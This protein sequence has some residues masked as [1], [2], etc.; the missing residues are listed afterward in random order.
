MQN[1]YAFNPKTRLSRIIRQLGTLALVAAPAT[2]G[3]WSRVSHGHLAAAAA[4]RASAFQAYASA[5]GLVERVVQGVQDADNESEKVFTANLEKAYPGIRMIRGDDPTKVQHT[6]PI[7]AYF[8]PDDTRL[9][10]ALECL[11][12]AHG[13]RRQAITEENH[14]AAIRIFSDG[15]HLVQDYFAHLNAPGRGNTGFSHGVGNLIDTNG[16]GK[17]ETPA[18]R[19]VDNVYWDCH[20]DLGN[21]RVPEHL[22][23]INYFH[24]PF[25]HKC[26]TKE[27]SWR[28]RAALEGGIEY[29]ECYLADDGPVRFRKVLSNGYVIRD[30]KRTYLDLI[31]HIATDNSEAGCKLAGEWSRATAPGSFMADYALATIKDPAAS[32]TW[33]MTVP[34]TGR[35][36]VYLRWPEQP[37]LTKAASV[38]VRIS[39]TVDGQSINQQINGN[40]WNSLGRFSLTKG[41]K[42][43]ILLTARQGE[44]I[45]ADAAMLIR[46]TE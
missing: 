41:E 27:E 15:L 13:L 39:G 38:S 9:H 19:V 12:I 29:M 30:G 17:P 46:V 28:Y 32:A 44:T 18:G 25:W 42:V 34:L 40:R 21:E 37:K 7:L 31:T 45:A 23:V 6:S 33:S 5:H 20:S 1:K 8:L 11:K 14:Q 35:Y 2:L 24:S 26:S 43:D 36:E 22:R 16:D 10:N 4:E 3:A